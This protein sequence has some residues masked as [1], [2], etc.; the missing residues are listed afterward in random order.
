MTSTFIQNNEWLNG[1][2]DKFLREVND[3]PFGS[4]IAIKA[5]FVRGKKSVMAIKARGE[6]SQNKKDGRNLVV[7]WEQDFKPFEVDFS[8]GYW[9]TIAEVKNPKH[10]D[11][12]FHD[13][14]P[15]VSDNKTDI[16]MPIFPKNQILF[17]PPGTGKTYNAVAKAVEIAD[18]L[19]F[20]T[21]KE[22]RTAIKMRFDE[23]QRSG[24][25]E[26]IT[27]HQAMSYE[28]FIEGIK[29][30]TN[31]DGS[32]RY[33]VKDGIFKILANRAQNIIS[34]KSS[35]QKAFEQL[36]DNF[37]QSNQNLKINLQ[38]SFFH[39]TEINER[40]IRFRNSV[41]KDKTLNLNK[42]EQIYNNFDNIEN[43]IS[44]GKRTYYK[45]LVEHV[46]NYETNAT[47][48]S[49]NLERTVFDQQNHV[50][51]IDEIN[52]GNVA[53]IF[54]ELITLIED[55]KRIG[56][57]EALKTTLP[58]SKIE[59]GVPQNLYLI[60][61][62]NTADRSVEA[63]DTAL[64]RRFSFSEIPPQYNLLKTTPEGIDLAVL[65]RTINDRIELLLDS[66]H[67]IGHAYF[68]TVSDLGDLKTTFQKN[69]LPL[70]QEYFYADYHK[71]GLV[72][73][74]NFVEKPTLKPY[75][76]KKTFAKGFDIE[77]EDFRQ[78]YRL[79]DIT[80]IDDPQIFIAI[81]A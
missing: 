64:R 38:Q 14:A 6:V 51:I 21:N 13:S 22:N 28:D 77:E 36:E 68:L 44:G 8:G 62:M 2:E 41:G 19:Y 61:T 65:L 50:L 76:A 56:R 37:E 43:L 55:S 12:I 16:E 20:E 40:L 70:L 47:S 4:Q 25:V 45:A 5:V 73:G 79:K 69:I 60:G 27:F 42:F 52:R 29:P 3:V 34:G 30:E 54:G 81:Y 10:I 33:E 35:F 7:E 63:L 48:L 11:I 72:L 9:N 75:E 49:E 46:L 23:L 53:N 74:E 66:D 57:D 17:G 71:I 31:D 32:V 15:S 1:Y 26:F 78:P 18:N 58:Y 24:Y 67:A 39:I 59:F 80:D